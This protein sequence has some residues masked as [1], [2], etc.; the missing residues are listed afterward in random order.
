M[1]SGRAFQVFGPATGKARLSAV[2]CLTGAP[3]NNRNVRTKRAFAGKTTYWHEWSKVRRWALPWRTLNV[4]RAVLYSIRS[5]M[6]NQ[7]RVTN[8]SVM[9]SAD[10]RW[11]ITRELLQSHFCETVSLFCDS[12]DRALVCN[13]YQWWTNLCALLYTWHFIR[14]SMYVD[15][16]EVDVQYSNWQSG[17]P[18]AASNDS[19]VGVTWNNKWIPISCDTPQKYVCQ[20][21]YWARYFTSSLIA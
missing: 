20:S 15:G 1:S 17:Y 3:E 2:D 16:R 21:E 4:S 13:N 6:R 19:C 18:D 8:A 14:A 7:W 10:R 12:V 5:E 11:K 9:W